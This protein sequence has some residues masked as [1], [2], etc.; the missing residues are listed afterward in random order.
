MRARRS[1]RAGLAAALSS[2][3]VVSFVIVGCS[4]EGGT[5]SFLD[6][7]P[8]EPEGQQLPQGS[9]NDGAVDAP[10]VQPDSGKAETGVDAG[11][12]A[13]TPGSACSTQ[14][15]IVQKTCGACGK[16]ATICQ[17][18]AEAGGLTW[19]KYSEPCTGETPGGCI[20]GTQVQEACGMCGTMTRT[21]NNV[22][23]FPTTTCVGQP[24]NACI[25]GGFDFTNA[26]CSAPDTFK[27][28]TCGSNCQYDQFG[29]CGPPPTYV[30]VPVIAQ[31]V[32]YTIAKLVSTKTIAKLTGTCGAATPPTISTTITPYTYIEVH[33]DN[34]K[35]AV[36]TIFNSLAPGGTTFKTNLA[37]YNGVTV[38]TGAEARKA[39]VKGVDTSG[40][41]SLTG[42]TMFSSLDG[43]Y[44]VTIPANGKVLVYVAAHNAYDAANP[45]AS[46]GLVKVNVRLDSLN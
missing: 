24:T 20:P 9:K 37:A 36:V 4:A 31:Q 46:T 2:C 8:Q 32:N 44:A 12:P 3:V 22:C 29:E 18:N 28:R 27:R 21:C 23:T 38:P 13:P 45:T 6:Q 25:I 10:F 5:D 26:G 35:S 19:S 42:S 41:S 30:K 34:A 7:S 14:D 40:N 33:N 39:C 43:T 15:E 16:Q 17:P 1:V 11:P